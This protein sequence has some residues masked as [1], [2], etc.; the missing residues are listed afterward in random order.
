MQKFVLVMI[1][2]LAL[3]S[4]SAYAERST[5]MFRAQKVD[6]TPSIPDK[7]KAPRRMPFLYQDGY[8]LIFSPHHP[9]YIIYIVQDDEVVYSSLVPDG[10]A[11]YELPYYLEGECMIQFVSESNCF[12][13]YIVFN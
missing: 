2:I 4:G 9:E 5:V 10:V 8:T 1:C 7:G 13:G 11:E 3:G 12:T 6:K